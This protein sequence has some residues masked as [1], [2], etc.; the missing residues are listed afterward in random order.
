MKRERDDNGVKSIANVIFWSVCCACSTICVLT[1][2]DHWAV[3]FIVI[4]SLTDCR[5]H[6][7]DHI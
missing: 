2:H 6:F 1:G 3:A 7:E 5:R 4:G